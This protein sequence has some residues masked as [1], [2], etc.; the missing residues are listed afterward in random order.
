ME[1]TVVRLKDEYQTGNPGWIHKNRGIHSKK[2][3]PK[4]APHLDDEVGK[5]ICIF[6]KNFQQGKPIKG[7]WELIA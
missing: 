2:S 7:S 1:S 3:S 5:V 6:G 4:W